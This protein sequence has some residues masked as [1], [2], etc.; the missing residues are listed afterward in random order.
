MKA[1]LAAITLS[2]VA[3]SMSV[4]TAQVPLKVQYITTGAGGKNDL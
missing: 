3:L 2:T 1:L 4:V